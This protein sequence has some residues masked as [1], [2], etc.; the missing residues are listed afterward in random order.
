MTRTHH[1]HHDPHS[2]RPKPP[3]VIRY[4]EKKS[5]CCYPTSLSPFT[6][7]HDSN[8]EIVAHKALAINLLF[9]ISWAKV[10]TLFLSVV[11]AP[12]LLLMQLAVTTGLLFFQVLWIQRLAFQISVGDNKGSYFRS[13]HII[14]YFSLC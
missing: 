11:K 14:I 1:P 2:S 10:T 9:L 13:L 4:S 5:A 7:P 3:S 12:L 8:T 6:V